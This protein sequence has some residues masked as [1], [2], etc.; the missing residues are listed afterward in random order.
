MF[1]CAVQDYKLTHITF[2]LVTSNI[3]HSTVQGID[4]ETTFPAVTSMAEL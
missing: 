1:Y 3:L 4:K 2:T